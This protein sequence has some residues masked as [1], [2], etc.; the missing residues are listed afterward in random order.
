LDLSLNQAA[1]GED[2][3]LRDLSSH[4]DKEDGDADDNELPENE[5]A[6]DREGGRLGKALCENSND[7]RDGHHDC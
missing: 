1:C 6:W 4:D 3:E 2:E 7:H 5:V